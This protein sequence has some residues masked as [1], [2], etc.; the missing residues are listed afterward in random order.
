MEGNDHP[1]VTLAHLVF[2]RGR[3]AGFGLDLP[4]LPLLGV[5][6]FG[7]RVHLGPDQLHDAGVCI[8]PRYVQTALLWGNTGAP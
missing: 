8:R 3:G 2:E 4:P 6:G 7:Q 5:S 1:S